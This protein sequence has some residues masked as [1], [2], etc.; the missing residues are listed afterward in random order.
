MNER[1]LQQRSAYLIKQGTKLVAA[2]VHRI[3]E[4]VDVNTLERRPAKQLGLNDIGRVTLT[5]SRA[6][7]FDAYADNRATG[8]FILIDRLTNATMGAGM[9]LGPGED[10][11][12]AASAA[13]GDGRV[14]PAERL[15]RLGQRP[16]TLFFVGG[17]SARREEL[18]HGLERRLWDDGYTAHVLGPRD[19]RSARLCAALGLIN[20]VL[21]DGDVE[22]SAVRTELA[23]EQVFEVQ[24]EEGEAGESVEGVLQ[25]LRESGTIR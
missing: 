1:P 7:L 25:R 9:I 6:L 2:E 21:A 22:L 19:I 3:H 11:P 20:L 8:A 13:S 4:R 18:A 23:P 15:E 17:D 12:D 10:E 24:C 5:A 16:A 14:S